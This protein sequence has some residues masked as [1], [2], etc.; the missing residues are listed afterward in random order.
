MAIQRVGKQTK[1]NKVQLCHLTRKPVTFVTFVTFLE[2]RI[3][4][5]GIGFFLPLQ[6]I[7]CQ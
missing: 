5:K 4:T 3:D 2:K 6:K 7:Y 1:I